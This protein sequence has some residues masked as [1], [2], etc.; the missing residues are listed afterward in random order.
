DRLALDSAVPSERRVIEFE[1][2]ALP[3][4]PTP[5][6][7]D[8]EDVDSGRGHVAMHLHAVIYEVVVGSD[9]V[10]NID[11]L[12]GIDDDQHGIAGHAT[13]FVDDRDHVPTR[14]GRKRGRVELG[15]D[16]A[17]EELEMLRIGPTHTG[18]KVRKRNGIDVRLEPE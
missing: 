5:A 9:H 10:R 17:A 12:V 16:V 6:V 3:Q 15:L 18:W 13:C 14:D 1:V 7:E 8:L 2:A 4:Q 11:G